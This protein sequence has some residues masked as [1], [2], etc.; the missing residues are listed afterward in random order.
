VSENLARHF[1]LRDDV[2]FLNHGSFG[3]CPREVF[4][5]YQS[6]QIE[7]ERQPVAFLGRDL[8]DRMRVPRVAL[9]AELGTEPDNIVGLV[10]ATEGLNIVAQSLD[11]QPGDEIV[12]TDHEYSAL[13]K[14]W[15]YMARHT[16]ARIVVV[17][18]PIPLVS[19]EAFT[20]AIVDAFTDRTRVLF[21]SHITSPTA[22]VFPIERSIRE[23]KA[24]KIWT[25][26]DG[27][28]TPGH[29]PLNLDAMDVDFYA[30]NCHKWLMTPKGSA[31]LYVRP[32]L[33]T[34]INPLVI[35]HGWTD[36]S[37]RPGAKG[38]FGNSPFIDEL[39]MQGTRDPAAW[40]AVPAA[41]AFRAEHGWSGVA[42]HCQMLAQETALRIADRTGLAPLSAPEFCAPQMV[43]IPLPDVGDPVEFQRQLMDRYQIEIPVFKWQEHSIARLSVQGYN[44]KAQMDAL[45][46]ALTDML[47]LEAS[48]ERARRHG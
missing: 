43:A 14:T 7:L 16:G 28:H 44:S 21:L 2:V 29:I 45:V 12:T 18:V 40:L 46:E 38:A 13:E 9:A 25:V 48:P 5:A 24:R 39:E 37:K 10:N 8:T 33:Q 19:E 17:K 3:A 23:A 11:L 6:W 47:Q 30:G 20:K 22:L 35:S 27:A 4:E 31:F 26:I 15:A 32:E 1:L 42:A 34:L 41:L 36:D